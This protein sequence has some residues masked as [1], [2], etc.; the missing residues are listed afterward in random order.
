MPVT[1]HRAGTPL[2]ANSPFKG[3]TVLL[4]VKPPHY[5][6][7]QA[8][9]QVEAAQRQPIQDGPADEKNALGGQIV[10]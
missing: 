3:T 4:G 2:P 7:E 10:E 6:R 5:L 9:R 1:F 8:K